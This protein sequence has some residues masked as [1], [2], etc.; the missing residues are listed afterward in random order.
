MLEPPSIT[1][2]PPGPSTEEPASTNTDPPLPTPAFELPERKNRL[3]PFAAFPASTSIVPPI[4]APLLSPLR[5]VMFPDDPSLPSPDNISTSPPT[6]PDPPTML[7]APPTLPLGEKLLSPPD[8]LTA[9][10]DRSTD[11]PPDIEMSPARPLILLSPL[12]MRT[13]PDDPDNTDPL[14]IFTPPLTTPDDD[15]DLVDIDT[16]DSPDIDTDPP[17]ATPLPK[18]DDTD[19]DPPTPNP[20]PASTDTEPAAPSDEDT[21]PT[22]NTMSPVVPDGPTASPVEITIDPDRPEIEDPE[23]MPMEPEAENVEKEVSNEI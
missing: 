2:E 16:P 12:A 23:L 22:D 9:A 14:A 13:D 17:G 5:I 20:D 7:T 4:E 18:P 15:E 19:T 1:T 3:P 8:I 6:P 11:T 10:P 21:D